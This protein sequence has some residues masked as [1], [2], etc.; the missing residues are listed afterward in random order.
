MNFEIEWNEW[1]QQPSKDHLNSGSA[2]EYLQVYSLIY[3]RSFFDEFCPPDDLC[4]SRSALSIS[5]LISWWIQANL[6]LNSW[7]SSVM[8]L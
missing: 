6:A 3:G 4:N 2:M 5:H 8:H 7:F 1:P